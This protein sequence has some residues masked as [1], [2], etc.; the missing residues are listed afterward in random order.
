MKRINLR[1]EKGF[2]VIEL[3]VVF[4]IIGLLS[5][6]VLTTTSTAR[7]NAR[8]AQRLADLGQ[9]HVALELY[10]DEHQSYPPSSGWNGIYSCWGYASTDS[11]A[12]G[13]ISQ[14]VPRYIYKLPRDPRNHINCDAQYIYSSNTVDY[15]LIAHNPEN[16][17]GETRRNLP[18]RD[19]TR[20]GNNGCWA[21]GY[22]T[23][24]AVS[25]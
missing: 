4:A 24:G 12:N 17:M 18:L 2:T 7:F 15:K 19:P 20:G 10:Y 21:F 1:S 23:P 14:L 5:S 3:I 9:I 8:S 25:W 11:N 22:W 13:W 16:C 6:F